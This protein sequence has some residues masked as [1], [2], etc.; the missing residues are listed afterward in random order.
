[1][2]L[3]VRISARAKI[4]IIK[5]IFSHLTVIIQ[6]AFRIEERALVRYDEQ[7]RALRGEDGQNDYSYVSNLQLQEGT[8][9]RKDGS[10]RT[11]NSIKWSAP[12]MEEHGEKNVVK[13]VCIHK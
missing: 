12:D 3:K 5:I 11:R 6:Y 13:V 9:T 8:D 7:K 10:I 4:Y 1:M 2:R